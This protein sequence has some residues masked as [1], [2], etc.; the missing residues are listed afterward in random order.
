MTELN[1]QTAEESAEIPE[2]VTPVEKVEKAESVTL[3]EETTQPTAT[4]TQESVTVKI[5]AMVEE[6]IAKVLDFMN[7]V[8]SFVKNIHI[9]V[10]FPSL[11]GESQSPTPPAI[12]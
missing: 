5:R 9:D 2:T 12:D 8:I 10:N 4:E 6:A 3:P 1:T 7:G 11:G